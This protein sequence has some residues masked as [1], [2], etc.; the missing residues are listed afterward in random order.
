[1]G[2]L[3]VLSVEHLDR[4]TWKCPLKM[5]IPGP[6]P[7]LWS[8][9]FCYGAHL[10]LGFR[11]F[12][13]MPELETCS[14]SNKSIKKIFFSQGLPL[15]C[16]IHTQL[17]ESSVISERWKIKPTTSL[18][19]FFPTKFALKITNCAID[20]FTS[21]WVL[22]LPDS[23]KVSLIKQPC[24][25]VEPAHRTSLVRKLLQGFFLCNFLICFPRWSPWEGD[26]TLDFPGQYCHAQIS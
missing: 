5:E 2:F 3:K 21:K 11:W 17:F 1:M 22:K 12:L 18:P 8:Q 14:C 25:P 6:H 10:K 19:V 15:S 23:S 7:E 16:L 20:K 26:V 13:Q 24:P 9:D 4:I